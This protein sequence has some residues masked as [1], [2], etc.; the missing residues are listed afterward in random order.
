[1]H[2][3]HVSAWSHPA[4]LQCSGTRRVADRVATRHRA[5]RGPREAP[6]VEV[7]DLAVAS[8]AT[9]SRA[10]MVYFDPPDLGWEP[11]FQSWVDA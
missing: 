2:Q 5:P 9:V 7:A 11:Y 4:T 8:P 6:R 3:C 10:G 1:M